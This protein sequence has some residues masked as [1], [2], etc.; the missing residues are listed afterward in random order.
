MVRH[1]AWQSV[2]GFDEQFYPV[3]FEDVDFC[4]RLRDAGFRI[5]YVPAAAAEHAGGHS[6]TTLSWSLRQQLWYGSLLRYASKHFS[7]S[8]GRAVALAVVI[9]CLVRTIGRAATEFSLEPFTAYSRVV[10]LTSLYL[11]HG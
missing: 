10:R 4:K 9:G 6:V 2:G 7:K 1:D 8:A 3:W 5:L 11:R